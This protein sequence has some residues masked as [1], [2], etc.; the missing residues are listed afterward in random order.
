MI[1]KKGS[2]CALP[3]SDCFELP[4]QRS[5][6]TIII[7]IN[8]RIRPFPFYPTHPK[9]AA[10]SLRGSLSFITPI[11]AVHPYYDLPPSWSCPIPSFMLEILILASFFNSPS[12]REYWSNDLVPI[13]LT[14]HPDMSCFPVTR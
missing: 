7:P 12:L 13:N 9:L 4:S 14:Y 2:A 6:A 5:I 3:F 1:K 11:E 10:K 8:I